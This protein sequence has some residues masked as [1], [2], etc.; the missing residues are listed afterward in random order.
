VSKQALRLEMRAR[1]AAQ[2]EAAGARDS[3]AAQE[4][5]LAWPGWAPACC[6]ACYLSVPGEVGTERI[7]AACAAAGKRVV[8]P[9]RRG[10]PATYGWCRFSPDTPLRAGPRGIREPASPD[11]APPDEPDLIVVPGVAFDSRGRRLGH[12][13]GCYDRLLAA[14]P[15]ALRAGLAFDWQMVAAV[16]VEAHDAPMDVVVTERMIYAGGGRPRL[17]TESKGERE[18]V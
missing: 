12:G 15:R 4:R 3:A 7:L 17:S 16:P 9:A 13:L 5:L 18:R 8:V 14:A 1:R 10:G 6:V 11:W 2:A